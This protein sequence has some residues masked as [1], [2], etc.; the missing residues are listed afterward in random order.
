MHHGMAVVCLLSGMGGSE[1]LSDWLPAPL[2]HL[3][4]HSI[5]SKLL[6][7]ADKLSPPLSSLTWFSEEGRK[8]EEAG[9]SKQLRATLFPPP[10]TYF[11]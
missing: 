11:L 4:G 8:E 2:D 7:G 1:T 6:M 5:L 3:L 9:R 10:P